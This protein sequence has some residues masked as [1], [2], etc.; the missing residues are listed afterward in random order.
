MNDI[1]TDGR[2]TVRPPVIGDASLHYEAVIES[3]PEVSTWLEWCHEGFQL[4]ESKLWVERAI[5]GH[6]SGEMHEFFVFEQDERFLGGCGL[7]RIDQRF[8]T[9]NLGYWVRTSAA[10]R[11]IASAATRLVARF[12]FEQ[13]GL[14]RIGIVAATGNIGSQRVME[15]VGAVREGVLRNG[16]RF[17]GENIDAVSSSLI[18]GD[19]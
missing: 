4:E 17:R 15:K 19:L 10:G 1:L 6:K 14:Q 13:L 12:G 16:I 3:I 11:G 9:A 5:E 2:I 8:L 18:P 7:N